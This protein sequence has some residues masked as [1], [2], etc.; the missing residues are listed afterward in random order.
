VLAVA[1]AAVMQNNA[2]TGSA[3][4]WS[5]KALAIT[6]LAALWL[7]GLLDQFHS[8][9]TGSRYVVLSGLMVA[10]AALKGA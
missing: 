5:V 6:L 9:E 2:L 7:I 3:Y 8:W 4:M 10:I 1:L